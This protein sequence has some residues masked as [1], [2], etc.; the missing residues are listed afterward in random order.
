[1]IGGQLT[2]G[3]VP[4]LKEVLPVTREVGRHSIHVRHLVDGEDLATLLIE[5][6]HGRA[7]DGGTRESW[8]D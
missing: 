5:A 1:M 8:C 6:R 3:L 2:S 4:R 7:Y